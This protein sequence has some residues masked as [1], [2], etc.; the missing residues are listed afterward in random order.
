M[1]IEFVC[2]GT[3]RVLA[4]YQGQTVPRNGDVV[5]LYDVDKSDAGDVHWRDVVRVEWHVG[6]HFG[7]VTH[8]VGVLVY[9]GPPMHFGERGGVVIGDVFDSSADEDEQQRARC[10]ARREMSIERKQLARDRGRDWALNF[11][12]S[13][14]D[15]REVLDN[16]STVAA[17]N[18]VRDEPDWHGV[19]E[20][21]FAD[22]FSAGAHEAMRGEIGDYTIATWQR[23]FDA[24]EIDESDES[25]VDRAA[26]SASTTGDEDNG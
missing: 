5:Y 15:V 1:N 8:P 11:A 20:A 24:A 16:A 25:I 9:V 2:R 18:A 3:D 10:K 6:E 7:D 23:A 22:W 12:A 19:N 26:R 14:G 17:E 21:A 13:G 4:S